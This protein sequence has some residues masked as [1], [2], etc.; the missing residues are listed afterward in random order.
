MG[1]VLRRIHWWGWTILVLIV[2]IA[3]GGG[4]V[5]GERA[6]SVEI[7]TVSP[8]MGARLASASVQISCVLPGYVPGRGSVSVTVDGKPLASSALMLRD[9]RV[10]AAVSLADGTHTADVEYSSLNIYSRQL[11]R[12]WTFS[13]DTTAP[14]VEVISPSPHTILS[15][16]VN[17]F[18]ATFSEDATATLEIDGLA[19]PLTQSE[20]G[21]A[22]SAEADLRVAEGEH[23]LTLSVTDPL[24]NR[25]VQKWQAWA[26]YQAPTVQAAEW[27][28]STWKQDSSTLGF[29]IADS[30]PDQLVMSATVDGRG[31]GLVQASASALAAL[32]PT[33]GGS[34]VSRPRT[35]IASA[36]TTTTSTLAR[37]AGTPS[38]APANLSSADKSRD[39]LLSTGV[40]NEG[41][42]E[43]TVSVEDIGG[44]VATWH[45]TFLV[46]TTE[47]FGAR[48]LGEGAIGQ[49][50]VTLQKLLAARGLYVGAAT[51]FY[52]DATAQAVTAYNASLNLSGG[53][54]VGADALPLLVGSIRI[55]LSERKLYLYADGKLEKTYNVAVGQPSYPTPVGSWKIISKVVDPTWTP[56]DSPWAK[57]AVPIGPGPDDPLGT[58]WMGLSAPGVGIH[59]T[60]EPWSIGSYASHGCIRMHIPD[61]EDL[62][63]RVLI[64]MPVDIV[65]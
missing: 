58:R 20:S 51:G 56:P 29:V 44:H 4:F 64:G 65:P 63:T 5:W 62:F 59:G 17:H 26:D 42:H 25:T 1:S 18:E 28:G 27:P 36:S 57:G 9:G 10:G 3:V 16:E 40:L 35:T 19:V 38:V 8:E 55:D 24:G 14:A 52:D 32:A 6:F 23:E 48:P 2:L 33:V 30:L 21:G 12:S 34:S 53:T 15:Q 7:S 41:T 49:D 50:V 61:A 47:T 22:K 60:N 39:Y 54:S 11:S 43:V 45:R 46:D 37:P 13:I 31:V